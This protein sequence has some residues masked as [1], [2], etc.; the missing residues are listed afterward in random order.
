MSDINLASSIVGHLRERFDDTDYVREALIIADIVFG[1]MCDPGHPLGPNGNDDAEDL[2]WAVGNV[3]GLV[4]GWKEA[5]PET[6]A[7]GRNDPPHRTSGGDRTA[8]ELTS[9]KLGPYSAIG[10]RPLSSWEMNM[11]LVSDNVF[12]TIQV[13]HD[14]N[15]GRI[16]VTSENTPGRG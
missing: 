6:I 14:Y 10:V 12:E 2:I 3:L 8:L 15:K 5:S 7:K 1:D 11:P 13:V 9:N 4:L 16:D